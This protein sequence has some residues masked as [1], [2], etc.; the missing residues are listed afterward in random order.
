MRARIR[1]IVCSCILLWFDLRARSVIYS[2]TVLKHNLIFDVFVRSM[3]DADRFN[4]SRVG[5][6]KLSG[7]NLSDESLSKRN[8]TKITFSFL[9]LYLRQFKGQVDV[10]N[11]CDLKK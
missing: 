8:N 6:Q 10:N 1:V 5:F 3:I 2:L 7:A 9:E 11:F 4:I